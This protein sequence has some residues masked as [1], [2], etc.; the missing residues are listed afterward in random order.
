L[1][2]QKLP[3]HNHPATP[4]LYVYVTDSGPVRFSHV[5][6]HPFTINRPPEKAGTFR[7]SPG[8]Y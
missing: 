5:E 3:V 8:R 7:L 6:D 1:P 2:H 4:T